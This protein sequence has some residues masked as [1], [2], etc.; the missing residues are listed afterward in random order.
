MEILKTSVVL[1]GVR[2]EENKGIIVILL[3]KVRLHKNLKG[4]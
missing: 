1:V 3:Q 4:G 2:D